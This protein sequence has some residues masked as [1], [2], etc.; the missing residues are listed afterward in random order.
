VVCKT[1]QRKLKN[2]T[3]TEGEPEVLHAPLV[4]LWDSVEMVK[5]EGTQICNNIIRIK[6]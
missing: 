2:S 4:D 1:L 6:I 5:V 3:K